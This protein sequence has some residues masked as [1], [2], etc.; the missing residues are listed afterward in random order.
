MGE[1]RGF[2]KHKRQ[3]VGYR[4]VK[5]RIHDFKELEL[6]LSPDQIKDQ[7]ARCMDC[8][9]PFCHGGGCPV[10]NRIPEFN[11]FIYKDKWQQA[12]E[13]L[14]STNNFPEITGRVCPAPCETACTL[15]VNDEPVL[16]KHIEFQIVERGFQ[17]GWI[18][19]MPSLEK[20]GKRVAVIGSGPAGLAAAQQLSRAGHE[21][22][23]FEKDESIGGM[24]RYGIPDFKLEKNIIDRRIEQLSAEGV[25]FQT[26]VDVGEDISSRYLKKMFD[27]ICLTMGARKP[28]DLAVQGRGFE[29]ILFAMDYLTV[30]NKLNSQETI[31]QEKVVNAKNKIVVVIGGGDTGSDC[32]GTSQRQGAKKIYQ[33]EILPKPPDT[34][35]ADTPWPMWPRIMRTSSSH[36]E[37]CERVWSAMTKKLSGGAGIR[38]N[39]LHACQV[40]WIN[41]DG[42]WKVKELPG[43]EFSLKV[44]LILLAMGFVHVVHEGL[45]K[46]LG[47]KLDE[48][49]NVTVN[50]FQT[51]NPQV[52]AAGDTINGASLIVTAI[53]SGRKAA[54]SIDRWL[55]Q[56]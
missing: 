34:R 54:E 13:N 3:Q 15:A 14:H 18:K 49:G 44:D 22:V 8:G 41:K 43:T 45:V 12:C 51:S 6:S 29:N 27:C 42:N 38:A 30:Q 33:L 23:V 52:F 50:D 17:E 10:G 16:I 11:E 19:P 9:I 4:P 40:E 36:Q 53:D 21:V 24:L 55:K 1:M 7:A 48:Q 46:D 5:E 28:R 26:G 31:E 35:P 20:T 39:Q 32:V 25:Q 56:Q 2:L 37:G 47:I